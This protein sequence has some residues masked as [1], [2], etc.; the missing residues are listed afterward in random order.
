MASVRVSIG[1]EQF[2]TGIQFDAPFPPKYFINAIVIN[3]NDRTHMAA[4]RSGS[5]TL[6]DMFP[7]QGHV[8]VPSLQLHWAIGPLCGNKHGLTFD[9]TSEDEIPKRVAGT[10]IALRIGPGPLA[11]RFSGPRIDSL[12]TTIFQTERMVRVDV[13]NEPY[14]LHAVVVEV[15]WEDRAKPDAWN[16]PRPE[17][18]LP[19]KLALLCK[20]REL[21]SLGKKNIST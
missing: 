1:A 11:G 16:H 12:Q 21:V 15:K 2:L 14:F 20:K 10:L 18:T 13:V 3:I 8:R 17:I 4:P 7:A 19:E 5:L 6:N 9:V